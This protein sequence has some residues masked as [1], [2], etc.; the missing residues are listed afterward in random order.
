MIPRPL[1]DLLRA[2]G[3]VV[4][5]GTGEAPVSGVADDSRETSPG[6]L[7]VCMPSA[8]SDSHGFLARAR[9]AGASAALVRSD[10][11]ARVAADLGLAWAQIADEGQRFTAAVGRICQ[12]AF[13]DPSARMR[14][15]GVTGTNGK[16]TTAWIVRDALAALGRRTAYLGTLGFAIGDDRRE[17][18]N[19]TPFP[20][21]MHRLLAEAVGHGVEDFVMEASSHALYQRRLAGV[22]F[23]IGVFT[24]LSQDHLDFHGTMEAYA[25]AKKLLFTEYAMASGKAFVGAVGIDDPTGASWLPDLPT[26]CV[27]FG[28]LGS[29]RIQAHSVEVDRIEAAL[30]GEHPFVAR[31]GGHFNVANLESAAGA[32]AALG[33]ASE[34]IAWALRHATPVPGRF[35]AVPND[36]GLGVIVDYAHTPDALAKLLASA[37]RLE[38]SQLIVVFGCG[39]DRDRTKRPK[40]AAVASELADLAIVTSDNP[41]TEDPEAIVREILAGIQPGGPHEVVV[42]RPAAI[43]RA[44]EIARPGDLVVIA[45]K[46][47]ENYQIIGRTKFP[48]DDRELAREALEARPCA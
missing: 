8:N 10:E 28:V 6:D 34:E 24:N 5:A 12:V 23:D 17:L 35:E 46:G 11:G 32:L 9:E 14:V 26:K 18:N 1:P 43:R 41:R 44:V 30:N 15:V 33:Y 2:A 19:T 27:P 48:M 40:M 21:Q 39:G 47:H 37:R 29:V 4:D 25:A 38:P 45:G 13:A 7:F 36:L 22:R 3:V 16:T 31:L 20:V 42:D